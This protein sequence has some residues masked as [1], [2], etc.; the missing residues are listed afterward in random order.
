MPI[1]DEF[2]KKRTEVTVSRAQIKEQKCRSCGAKVGAENIKDGYMKCTYC[3]TSY[4]LDVE[5]H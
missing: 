4:A 5:E 1:P 2:T 3:G